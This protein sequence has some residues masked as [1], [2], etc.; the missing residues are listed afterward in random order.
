MSGCFE[1]QFARGGTVQNPS[2]EHAILDEMTASAGDALGVEWPRP[3]AARP[4]RIVN[5]VDAGSKDLL[6]ELF[7]Q[8]TGLARDRAA[9]R[10]A[11]HVSHH[12]A[13]NSGIEHDR[14]AT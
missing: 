7:A 13:G 6:T 2:F 8:K 4:K 11:R 10:G 5:D 1:A 12:R 14:H 3:Q 9:V